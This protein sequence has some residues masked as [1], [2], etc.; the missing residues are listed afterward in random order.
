MRKAVLVQPPSAASGI[1][2]QSERQRTNAVKNFILLRVAALGI[3]APLIS[4]FHYTD[5]GPAAVTAPS[6]RDYTG[7]QRI[8]GSCLPTTALIVLPSAAS[9]IARQK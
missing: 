7:T 4:F 6:R 9:G 8:F 1:V 5:H 3:R 2:R